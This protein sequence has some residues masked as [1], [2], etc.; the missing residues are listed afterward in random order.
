[1]YE[2]RDAVRR[3]VAAVPLEATKHTYILSRFK[4]SEGHTAP[5]Q[6]AAERIS[7]LD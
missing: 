1:M 2:H 5:S 4:S 7:V 3:Y 6:D